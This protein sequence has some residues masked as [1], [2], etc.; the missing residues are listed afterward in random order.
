MPQN[1]MY[2]IL[3]SSSDNSFVLSTITVS[4]ESPLTAF[5]PASARVNS[6]DIGPSVIFDCYLYSPSC[7]PSVLKRS[8]KVGSSIISCIYSLVMSYPYYFS[9]WEQMALS[10]LLS[11]WCKAINGNKNP[12]NTSLNLNHF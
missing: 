11:D 5:V 8:E 12:M 2:L 7:L 4:L 6:P 10:Q 3:R 1:Y 9:C